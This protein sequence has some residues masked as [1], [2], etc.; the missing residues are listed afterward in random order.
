M[1]DCNPGAPPSIRKVYFT[2]E[3]KKTTL[4]SYVVMSFQTLYK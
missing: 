2:V 4:R 1:K 3:K